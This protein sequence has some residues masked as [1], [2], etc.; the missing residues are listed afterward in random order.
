[1]SLTPKQEM[2]CKHIADG[3][4]ELEAVKATG[5]N[6]DHAARQLHRLK[7]NPEVE[8][9]IIELKAIAHIQGL[10]A[11]MSHQ[12]ADLTPAVAEQVSSMEFLRSTFSDPRQ[13]MKIRL[14]AAIAV[15]PYEEA[16]VAAK[17]K[18]EDAIDSAKQATASGKFA[19]FSNQVDM[20]S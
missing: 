14:A 7:S 10:D 20:F 4:G 11:G 9:R 5:Y 3:L 1:M 18:K 12:Q 6:A 16:K 2:Y 15:L 8:K 13:P 17:G 19:T